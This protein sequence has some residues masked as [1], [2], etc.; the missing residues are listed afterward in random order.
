MCNSDF[1]CATSCALASKTS[2]IDVA[3]L[4]WLFAKSSAIFSGERDSASRDE[5]DPDELSSSSMDFLVALVRLFPRCKCT[6]FDERMV[7]GIM[8]R[9]PHR[10]VKRADG[11]TPPT[12]WA[13]MAEPFI[14]CS[15]ACIAAPLRV[16]VGNNRLHRKNI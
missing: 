7:D 1:T 3:S 11:F 16:G 13:R 6:A 4:N 5:P 2:L 12:R 10:V 14:D 8:P 15:E 9:A